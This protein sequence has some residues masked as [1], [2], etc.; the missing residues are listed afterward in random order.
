MNTRLYYYTGTG[1][2]LWIARQLAG[3][4]QG[5]TAL[6]SLGTGIPMPDE[7]CER[8]GIV[9][10]VH[11]WGVPRRVLEFVAKMTV[12]PGCYF[13]AIAVNAGQVAAT[14]V[15]LKKSLAARGILLGSGFDLKM[16]SNYIPWGGAQPE[17]KQEELFSQAEKKLDKIAEI[18]QLRENEPVEKGPWWQNLLFSFANKMTFAHVPKLDKD[19][20]VGELCNGC[21]LCTRVCPAGNIR[22]AAGKPV[23]QHHCEQ[24][25]ACLHW[26]PQEAIQYAKKTAGKKRYH[27]PKISAADM[28][29]APVGRK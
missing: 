24:C 10:P 4:L 28:V 19:F 1:N 26:C 11:I 9:F 16:P 22:M 13:F 7:S 14:L 20:W 8:I 25:L 29:G 3:R 12:Q 18:V 23:W 5:E 21:G 27:H 17:K 6:I 2:S 15:Q